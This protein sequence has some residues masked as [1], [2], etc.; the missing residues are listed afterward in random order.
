MSRIDLSTVRTDRPHTFASEIRQIIEN[1]EEQEFT[2]VQIVHI[3][4]D[5]GKG[6]CRHLAD[7]R[8][9][10]RAVIRNLIRDKK[11]KV[12]RQGVAGNQTP[13]IYKNVLKGK[14][15]GQSK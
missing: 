10:V 8:R 13:G 14:K 3:A 2:A 5:N 12:I 6:I 4:N 1:V 11:V 9:S 7:V 15:N